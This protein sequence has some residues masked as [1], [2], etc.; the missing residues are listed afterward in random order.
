MIAQEIVHS[1]NLKS[2]KQKAFLLKLD[3]AKAFDRIEWAFIAKAMKRQGFKDHFINLVFQCI[4]TSLLVLIS[5]EPSTSFNPQREIRQGCPLSPYLLVLVVNE[6]SISLQA[7]MDNNNLEGVTLA[8]NCPKIHSLLFADDLII[9]G[10][11]NINEANKIKLA[12]KM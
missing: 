7:N 6:L 5:G 4:C 3:L 1:F 10:Q 8:P 12:K 2:W 11:A 9:C